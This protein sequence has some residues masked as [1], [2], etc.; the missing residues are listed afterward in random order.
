[1]LIRREQVGRN[2]VRGHAFG[3]DCRLGAVQGGLIAAA[4]RDIGAFAGKG[5]G[6]RQTDAAV[7]AGDED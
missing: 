4:N 3:G 1:L 5:E 2:R 7:A 6:D